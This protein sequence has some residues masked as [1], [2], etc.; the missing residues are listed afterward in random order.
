[1]KI[2]FSTP[3]MAQSVHGWKR[4]V[5]RFKNALHGTL[6]IETGHGIEKD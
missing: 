6:V 1:M 4:I 2:Y 3:P 5:R